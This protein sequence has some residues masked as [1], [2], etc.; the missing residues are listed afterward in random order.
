[1]VYEGIL[2]HYEAIKSDLNEF[3][4]YL[5]ENGFP[6]NSSYYQYYDAYMKYDAYADVAKPPALVQE[7]LDKGRIVGICDKVDDGD[8]IFVNGKEV[9]LA[10]ID[11][12]EKGTT[13]GPATARMKEL[14]LGKMVTVYFDRIHHGNVS[15]GPGRGILAMEMKKNCTDARIGR[16]YLST[17]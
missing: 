15:P 17:I 16:V 8:T 6:P 2:P 12:A 1:M 13:V 10:G 11:S 5:D 4:K 3:K 7:E 9:R 14:V